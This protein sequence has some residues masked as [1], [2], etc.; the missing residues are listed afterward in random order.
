MYIALQYTLHRIMKKSDP[1]RL[2]QQ[3]ALRH[4]VDDGISEILV[5]I[6]LAAGA[7]LV[8]HPRGAVLVLGVAAG[9]KWLLPR[10]RDRITTP[11][12]GSATLPQQPFKLLAGIFIYGVLSGFVVLGLRA[13][14]G[15]HTGPFGQYR[16][17]PFFVALFL[18]GGF[19]YFART[20][21]LKRFYVYLAVTVGGGLAF[22]LT[23]PSGERLQAY[24]ELITL[25]WLLSALFVVTGS[26]VLARF[27][28]HNPVVPSE[29]QGS[30]P[31]E[32]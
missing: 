29:G 22:T 20:T 10:L 16:W 23:M 8:L 17:L 32:Q 18:S 28:L 12:V 1:I 3:A 27:I 30:D 6:L 21:N 11:R 9:L 2:M 7:L 31:H 13:A 4:A 5:G 24:G 14:T 19:L 15:G 26:A 25:L